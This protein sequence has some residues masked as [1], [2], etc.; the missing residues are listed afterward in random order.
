M[1]CSN[2][3][4][5]T[6][7]DTDTEPEGDLDV[8]DNGL[9]TGDIRIYNA[10]EDCGNE[11]EETTFSVEIDL[12]DAVRQHAEQKHQAWLAEA[13]KPR[14]KVKDKP[15]DPRTLDMFDRCRTCGRYWQSH[16]I[17]V[18]KRRVNVL[19]IAPA[20]FKD[21]RKAECVGNEGHFVLK[22]KTVKGA[23]GAP[24][25]SVESDITRTDDTQTTDRRGRKI[26]NPRYMRRLYGIQVEA[27]IKCNTCDED[28][29]T[30]N[31]SDSVAASGMEW[32]G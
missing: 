1:K 32:I 11:L 6:A 19:G 20:P 13:E 23:N 2:C 29:A 5:F 3:P 26:R 12:T 17:R 10:C 31:Y 18:G 24:D 15:I 28:I 16:Y 8:D 30:G 14:P 25:L 9:I 4:Q 21:A 7:K 27:T 22:P